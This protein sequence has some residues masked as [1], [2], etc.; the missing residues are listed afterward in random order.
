MTNCEITAARSL[1]S[2]LLPYHSAS[3]SSA[4]MAL[5][6]SLSLKTIIAGENALALLCSVRRLKTKVVRVQGWILAT[7]LQD[8]LSLAVPTLPRE[9]KLVDRIV[10]G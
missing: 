10:T 1:T 7:W 4:S 2:F 9:L 6:Q 3:L 5:C 8:P